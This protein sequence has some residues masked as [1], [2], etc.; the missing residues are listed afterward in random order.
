[1]NTI[2]PGFLSFFRFFAPFV[3]A[4]LATN[5]IRVKSQA[6]VEAVEPRR[7]WRM[8]RQSPTHPNDDNMSLMHHGMF[9][10]Q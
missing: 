9:Y 3:W 7:W 10:W 1:M 8:R 6:V 5:S 2:V 4:K